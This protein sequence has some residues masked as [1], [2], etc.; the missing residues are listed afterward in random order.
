M[1]VRILLEVHDM[2]KEIKRNK[3][4]QQKL[5]TALR[6]YEKVQ[7][8]LTAIEPRK[9]LL[10]DDAPQAI[11]V[12]IDGTLAIR[13]ARG[14][15][16]FEKCGMDS[17]CEQVCA[18]VVALRPLFKIIVMSGREDRFENATRKWLEKYEVPFDKLIMRKTDDKRR[19]D[20]VK[21]ELYEQ[22]VE[23]KY[24]LFFALDDR[25]RVIKMWRTLGIYV[26]DVNQL[27]VDF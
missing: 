1:R 13:G 21:K 9:Q 20:I 17:L 25:P 5:A 19:D 14:V 4:E 23:G 3:E 16:E 27:G 18:I 12:D 10:A 8:Q 26:L 22:H 15:F 11:L 6:R 2:L 24:N 7:E